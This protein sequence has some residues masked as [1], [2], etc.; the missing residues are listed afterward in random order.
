[1][2]ESEGR[3]D[4]PSEFVFWYQVI[5]H[6]ISLALVES[7]QKLAREFFN[8]PLEEKQKYAENPNDLIPQGYGRGF[9]MPESTI[10]DWHDIF[11]HYFL[12]LSLKNIST[13]PHK[14][15]AY[16]Y[17]HLSDTRIGDQGK[18]FNSLPAC[19]YSSIIHVCID[20]FVKREF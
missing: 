20:L 5:N 9:R 11:L 3:F 4:L 18:K 17:C 6:G 7:A 1:L 14:P 19:V 12:P 2:K 16:R 8:L 10:L 13:W 15:A